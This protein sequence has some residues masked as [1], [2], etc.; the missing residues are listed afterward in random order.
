MFLLVSIFCPKSFSSS[1][2]ADRVYKAVSLSKHSNEVK[3]N[4]R[5][6][7]NNQEN[8]I[9]F[10]SR[11]SVFE[12]GIINIRRNKEWHCLGNGYTE[13]TTLYFLNSLI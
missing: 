8:K 13:L 12:K 4:S 9:N 3:A 1:L 11:D 2:N 10:K 7:L 6:V 5:K